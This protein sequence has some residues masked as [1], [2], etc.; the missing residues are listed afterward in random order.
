MGKKLRRVSAFAALARALAKGARGG[1]P[2]RR[3]I[4]A[5]PRMIV[6]SVRGEYDGRL[7]LALMG[8]ALAYVLSPLDA[9]PE[10]ILPL[11]GLIDDGVIIAWLAGSVLAETERFLSWE[12]ARARVVP[13]EIVS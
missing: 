8:L 9:V 7:R 4:A 11:L 6:A 1:P 2:L 5:V 12:A 10:A 3:R 13:G